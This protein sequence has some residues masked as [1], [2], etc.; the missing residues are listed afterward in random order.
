M[1][2]NDVAF[3]KILHTQKNVTFA[4]SLQWPPDF[5]STYQGTRKG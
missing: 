4:I 1:L 5:C 3:F 2:Q